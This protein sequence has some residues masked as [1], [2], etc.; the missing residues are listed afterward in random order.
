MDSDLIE[1][2]LQADGAIR[3]TP[4][5]SLED[6]S[7]LPAVLAVFERE[8][9][10]KH[11]FFILDLGALGSLPPGWVALLFELTARSRR[12][13]GDLCVINLQRKAQGDLLNFQPET[14]LCMEEMDFIAPLSQSVLADAQPEQLGQLK[15]AGQPDLPGE[16]DFARLH[17]LAETPGAQERRQSDQGLSNDAEGAR[18]TIDI[19]SRVDALYRA[20]DFVLEIAARMGFGESDLSKIKICVY[21]ASLN[22]IEHAYHSDSTKQVRVQVAAGPEKL[23]IQIID[24]GDGF[25]AK[26]NED[27]DATAAAAARRT[28]GMGLHIIRR[29]MDKVNYIRDA[30]SGNRLIMEKLLPAQGQRRETIPANMLSTPKE[31]PSALRGESDGAIWPA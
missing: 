12:R 28:G 10:K 17:G 26:T 3:I 11:L 29:S 24:R 14:Y 7:L 4:R 1:S 5:G 15:P 22:A 8:F 16:P 25:E 27:F 19:P 21:E 9:R 13:G 31:T 23:I 20:C 2:V 30:Q 18:S 6:I